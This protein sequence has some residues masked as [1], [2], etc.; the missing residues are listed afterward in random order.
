MVWLTLPVHDSTADVCD[1]QV[2]SY[3]LSSVFVERV[4]PA[5]SEFQIILALHLG[6]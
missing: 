1:V 2:G 4:Q 6:S 5:E 3:A